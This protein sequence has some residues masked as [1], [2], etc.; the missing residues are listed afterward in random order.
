MDSVPTTNESRPCFGVRLCAELKRLAV[1]A[2]VV[3]LMVI[4][5][6]HYCFDRLNEEIRVRVETLLREHYEGLSVTVSSARRIAGQ[7]I[8]I[9]GVSIREAGGKT[10]PVLVEIDEIHADCDTRLP[11]FLTRPLRVTALHLHR[12]K[13]RGERKPSGR[14]NLSHL[15][16]LPPCD[17]S[18]PPLARITDA[19][20]ELVDPAQHS[21]GGLVLR[22]IELSVT[23]ETA[24]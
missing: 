16:P 18:M 19:S 8:E 20:L 13:L 22:N 1:L 5:G 7:G 11:D 24:G 4:A 23:P 10:A 15:L 12:L 17:S 9:R 14:W 2:I 21:A 6:K 3:G